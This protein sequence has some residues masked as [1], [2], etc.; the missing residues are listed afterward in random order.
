[1]EIVYC[2]ALPV[3]VKVCL[4]TVLVVGTLVM[5]VEIIE[6]SDLSPCINRDAG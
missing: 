3:G 4:G 2:N 1:M 5:E 6:D